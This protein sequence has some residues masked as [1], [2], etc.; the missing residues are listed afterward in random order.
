MLEFS[1]AVDAALR[2]KIRLITPEGVR[3]PVDPHQKSG[4]RENTLNSVTFAKP[5]PQNAELR[6]ELPSG[7]QDDAGRPLANAAGLPLKFKTGTLPP[8]AKFSG[9]FGIVE[10]NEGGVLPVTCR[11]N[12]E[13]RLQLNERH[14]TDDAEIIAAMQALARLSSRRRQLGRCAT[15]GQEEYTDP[16]YARELSFLARQPGVRKRDLP[17]PGGSAEFEVV[18]IPLPPSPASILSKWKASCSVQRCFSVQAHVC[19]CDRTGDQPRRASEA[20]HRQ[21]TR[22]G[23]LARPGQAVRRCRSAR[24]RLPGQTLVERPD[25]CTGTCSGTAGIAGKHLQ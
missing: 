10:L 9:G 13:A 18:G 4:S 23:D 1:A 8:L 12:I 25:R 5:F 3:L 22:L 17:K 24:V 2:E 21:C 7:I 19:A 16:D 6:L 20:Q 15:A 11:Q 14:L